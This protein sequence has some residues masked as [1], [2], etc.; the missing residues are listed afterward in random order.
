MPVINTDALIKNRVEAIRAYHDNFG[1]KRAELDVSGGI[2][3]AL[4]L[5]LLSESLGPDNVT[6]VYSSIHSSEASLRR[7]R[8]VAEVAGVKLVELDLS[9]IYDDIALEA[10]RAVGEA[11]Y[12]TDEIVTRMGD[13]DAV[14]G[15]LR[16]CLRAPIGRYLN[17]MTGGGIRH[18][19]GNEDEDRWLRFYQKGGDG[20]VDTNPLAMLSK[21]EV[22]QLA[23]AMNVPREIIDALPTPDLWG[24]GEKHNDEEELT[25]L[26]GGVEWSYSRINPETNEYIRVGTIE[27]MS[28]FVD[29]Y[30]AHFYDS[31]RYLNGFF[32]TYG[33]NP[34]REF[35][36][37]ELSHAAKF[38]LTE[39]HLR[40]ALKWERITR[41]K[42]NEN[43]PT[44]GERH[45][46]VQ[47]G[48]L[49]DELP[50]L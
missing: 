24:T 28:R 2:D 5:V 17:R 16:S 9:D 30:N 13:E 32:E 39:T 31:L 34:G 26:S 8:L 29:S 49:T 18:G 23:N 22:Y 36:S 7:A 21:G 42:L 1:I 6:A 10:M 3:S 12:D 35:T 4:M 46:L 41:H 27:R 15:S 48:I 38:G 47:E 37:I 40:S 25:R 50:K 14:A 20:E 43:C 44:L 45:Y 19:T 11:G 33:F